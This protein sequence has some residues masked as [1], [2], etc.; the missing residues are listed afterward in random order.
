[1][2]TRNEYRRPFSKVFFQHTHPHMNPTDGQSCMAATFTPT[3]TWA[4]ACR[5]PLRN[6]HLYDCWPERDQL[7]CPRAAGGRGMQHWA[8][9]RL[10]KSAPCKFLHC[11]FKE[12]RALSLVCRF[13]A[14]KTE[15]GK[16]VKEPKPILKTFRSDVSRSWNKVKSELGP[17]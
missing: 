2:T 9:E 15:A 3:Q 5:L 1:M 16:K 6:L 7:G 17:T 12:S 11:S 14:K 4:K 10:K 13:M 8:K